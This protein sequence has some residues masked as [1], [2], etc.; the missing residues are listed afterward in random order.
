M[1]AFH[2]VW[3]RLVKECKLNGLCTGLVEE[4]SSG[5]QLDDNDSS[6]NETSVPAGLLGMCSLLGDKA[7]SAS[8]AHPLSPVSPSPVTPA[9]SGTQPLPSFQLD[10]SAS[11]I[12]SNLV[13]NGG[14]TAATGRPPPAVAVAS[15]LSLRFYSVPVLPI[16]DRSLGLTRRCLLF[17]F[18]LPVHLLRRGLQ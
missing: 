14:H 10:A 2:H 7:A 5:A 13:D 16:T 9:I 18:L 4:G 11:A 12:L 3:G 6:D 17:R 1:V 15:V 8:S